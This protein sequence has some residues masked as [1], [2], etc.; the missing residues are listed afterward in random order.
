MLVKDGN[1]QSRGAELLSSYRSGI[2]KAPNKT[3]QSSFNYTE[4]T[5]IV[6]GK[7]EVYYRLTNYRPLE[8][9]TEFGVE[10]GYDFTPTMLGVTRTQIGGKEVGEYKWKFPVELH[11][12]HDDNQFDLDDAK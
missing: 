2:P 7:Q 5:K 1:G 4:I 10:V 12:N 9:N 6:N 11:V 8:G 3:G